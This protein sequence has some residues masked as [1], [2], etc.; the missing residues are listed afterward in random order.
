M[1][2]TNATLGYDGGPDRYLSIKFPKMKYALAF[3][4]AFVAGKAFAASCECGYSVNKTNSQY[5][6]LFT[7]VIETDF[8][9]ANGVT[10]GGIGST[11]WAPQIYNMSASQSRGEFG[12]AN[13][14]ENIVANPLPPGQ[15]KTDPAGGGDPG[16]QLWARSKVQDGLVPTAELASPRDDILYG[17]FRVGMKV[18]GVNGTCSAFF[19]YQYV[20]S[21]TFRARPLAML[22]DQ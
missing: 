19:W 4:L 5:F 17:S 12:R 6:G 9:H 10:Y 3:A 14:L 20:D 15:W 2:K 1:H 13:L 21:R 16:L 7:D 11:G 18:T 8:L 22:A